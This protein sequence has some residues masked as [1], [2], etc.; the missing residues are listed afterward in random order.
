M[1]IYIYWQFKRLTLHLNIK[2]IQSIDMTTYGKYIG[3][4]GV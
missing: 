1:F 4:M 2:F 3:N